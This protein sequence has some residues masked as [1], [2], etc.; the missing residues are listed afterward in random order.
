MQLRRRDTSIRKA[1]STQHNFYPQSK[2]LPGIHHSIIQRVT[3]KHF[4]V[5][6]THQG[7]AW[8]N[9]AISRDSTTFIHRAKLYLAYDNTYN[10]KG[11]VQAFLRKRDTSS[12]AWSNYDIIRDSTTFTLKSKT[13]PGIYHTYN[14]KVTCKHKLTYN[15]K[16]D[17][18]AQTYLAACMVY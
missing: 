7:K 2:A 8:S 15:S 6:V 10:S 16:S 9:Y 4:C 5:D 18:Q 17:V 13:L 12:K 14:S 3:C 11:D 1:W